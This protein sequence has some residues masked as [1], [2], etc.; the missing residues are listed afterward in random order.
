MTHDDPRL[1]T[2]A[3]GELDA[4]TADDLAEIEAL[5]ATDE[6]ARQ[7]VEE[8]RRAAA[9]L[10][11]DLALGEVLPALTAAQRQAI[12]TAAGQTS[13]TPHRTIKLPAR[14]AAW[15]RWALATAACAALAGAVAWN[16]FNAPDKP[17]AH[18]DKVGVPT[19]QAVSAPTTSPNG[20]AVRGLATSGQPDRWNRDAFGT[21]PLTRSDP[22]AATTGSNALGDQASPPG[23]ASASTTLNW[24]D[25]NGHQGTIGQGE[26]LALGQG[27]G[28]QPITRY[29]QTPSLLTGKPGSGPTNS[30]GTGAISGV[31]GTTANTGLAL[32]GINSY[33]GQTTV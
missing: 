19:P 13:A 11:A 15:A 16:V 5:L 8:T 27:S 26:G 7:A 32:D 9:S 6:T 23:T 33:T 3:L 18:N 31:A 25:Q 1:T 20:Q 21:S 12:T 29:Y 14:R 2:Y 22:S 10:K 17:V 24:Q 30:A 28:Q 4:L